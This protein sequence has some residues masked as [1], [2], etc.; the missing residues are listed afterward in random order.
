MECSSSGG[1]SKG[2]LLMLAQRAGLPLEQPNTARRGDRGL[3]AARGAA[4]GEKW[5]TTDG[6]V[7]D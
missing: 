7:D 4:L 3:Q 1:M 2:G 5:W 6:E